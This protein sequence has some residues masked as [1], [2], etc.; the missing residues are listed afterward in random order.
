MLTNPATLILL[1]RMVRNR[2]ARKEEL[3]MRSP[4][5]REEI[6]GLATRRLKFNQGITIQSNE[7]Q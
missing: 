5:R 3:K 7:K 6:E 4:R 1:G 2:E